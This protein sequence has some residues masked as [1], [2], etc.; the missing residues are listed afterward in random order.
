MGCPCV[1]PAA[2]A[3]TAAG[4]AAAA[5]AAAATVALGER[6]SLS[7]HFSAVREWKVSRQHA[8]EWP[9]AQRAKHILMCLLRHACRGG[10]GHGRSRCRTRPA[11]AATQQGAGWCSTAT[12]CMLLRAL[13]AFPGCMG[14]HGQCKV[15]R[16]DYKQCPKGACNGV[17]AFMKIAK[18]WVTAHPHSLHFPSCAAATALPGACCGARCLHPHPRR[19]QRERGCR[20]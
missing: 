13:M 2:A 11:G 8:L 1:L 9:A 18:S 12:A 5:A 15:V 16:S 14:G 3:A 19:S 7:A 20:I 6:G 17:P 10:G 4:S